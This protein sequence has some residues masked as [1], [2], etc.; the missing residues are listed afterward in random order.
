MGA[1]GVEQVHLV[2]RGPGGLAGAAHV[3]ERPRRAHEGGLA[4]RRRDMRPRGGLARG[5][6]RAGQV[7]RP[8][9]DR[10][11]RDQLQEGPQVHDRGGRPRPGKGRVGLRRPR[12]APAQRLLRPA[13]RRPA[14][15]HRGRGAEAHRRGAMARLPA[16][17]GA[18][19]GV[20]GRA[21][22]RG[23]RGRPPAR[24][25]V[26]VQ[27]TGVRRAVEEGQAQARRDP[28]LH[29]PRRVQRPGGGREQQDKG[30]DQAGLRLQERG[31]PDR[32][33]HAQVLGPEAGPAGEGDGVTP[34][35]TNSRSLH[36][37]LAYPHC[38]ISI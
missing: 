21:R 16:Q 30:G 9:L 37:S 24:L 23:G 35:H 20:P 17:G 22:P 18:S 25:G 14:R 3:Q 13:H 29:R 1:L 26:Q 10:R 33:H 5:G 4:H 6:Q 38:D 19:R 7:R 27:D 34:T 11:R 15:R 31:R 12:Q 32:A 28:A 36:N 2:L 8:A